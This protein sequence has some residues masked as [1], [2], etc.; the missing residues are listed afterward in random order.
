M[1]QEILDADDYAMNMEVAIRRFK[2]IVSGNKTTPFQ[3]TVSETTY[4]PIANTLD[5]SNFPST[6]IANHN[7]NHSEN[8]YTVD[9]SSVYTNANPTTAT[10][11]YHKL[12]KLDLPNFTGDI[13]TWKHVLV[14]SEKHSKQISSY[15][16]HALSAKKHILA[17]YVLLL[18]F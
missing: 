17:S 8:V 2:D 1:E 12:P 11:F 14:V 13:L 3:Q 10:N 16:K 9:N 6:S 15:I 18:I 4:V 5:S 7:S